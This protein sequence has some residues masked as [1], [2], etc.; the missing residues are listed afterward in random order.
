LIIQISE[1]R[2]HSFTQLPDLHFWRGVLI[3][4]FLAVITA[5]VATVPPFDQLGGVFL[6][7]IF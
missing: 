7:L 6:A 2:L 5:F 1:V 3:P 4:A